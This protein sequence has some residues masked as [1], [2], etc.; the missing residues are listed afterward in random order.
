MVEVG[1]KIL[2]Q[3]TKIKLLSGSPLF[4]VKK[5]DNGKSSSKTR[6]IKNQGK[7]SQ[8]QE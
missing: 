6:S 5:D 7:V 1:L 2:A 4:A 8:M 3:K